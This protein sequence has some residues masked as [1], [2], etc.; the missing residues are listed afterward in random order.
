M[1]DGVYV[2]RVSTW[3]CFNSQSETTALRV[4]NLDRKKVKT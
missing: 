4:G 3:E 2:L 1:R